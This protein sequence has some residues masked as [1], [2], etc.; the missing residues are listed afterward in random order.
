MLT[1]VANC[2]AAGSASGDEILHGDPRVSYLQ[3]LIHSQETLA[4]A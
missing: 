3:L 4:S 1:G 2:S